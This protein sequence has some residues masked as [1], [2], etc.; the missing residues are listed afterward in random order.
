MSGWTTATSF[1]RL[2]QACTV[3]LPIITCL[4]MWGRYNI[5]AIIFFVSF[6]FLCTKYLIAV[7]L[8]NKRLQK[9]MSAIVC[10]FAP[11]LSPLVTFTCSLIS[12]KDPA[13]CNNMHKDSFCNGAPHVGHE[14]DTLVE[15]IVHDYILFWFRAVSPDDEDFVNECRQVFKNMFTTFVK[16][17][18]VKVRADRLMPKALA[19]VRNHVQLNGSSVRRERVPTDAQEEAIALTNSIAEYLL[20]SCAPAALN[21]MNEPV[22]Q[23]HA[24][25]H[26][27]RD[28]V[29]IM[30]KEMLAFGVLMPIAFHLS[31]PK[32]IFRSII[33]VVSDTGVGKRDPESE[34]VLSSLLNG[35]DEDAKKWPSDPEKRVALLSDPLSDPQHFLL[36]FDPDPKSHGS[37]HV[38]ECKYFHFDDWQSITTLF[39]PRALF[40]AALFNLLQTANCHLLIPDFHWTLILGWRKD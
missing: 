3:L 29:F 20:T 16:E 7:F 35:T 22:G 19:A 32:L 10:M 4:I 39:F 37:G 34:A 13:A 31:D 8:P 27:Q 25:G 30:V 17:K 6:S 11:A 18:L 38:A 26:V 9:R 23:Q 21:R 28:S 5:L 15:H 40:T 12:N 2:E 14:I 36:P 1:R 24:S 33:G